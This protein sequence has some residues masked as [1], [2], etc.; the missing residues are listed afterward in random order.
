MSIGN[1]MNICRQQLHKTAFLNV[2]MRANVKKQNKEI[3]K[4]S[5]WN[6]YGQKCGQYVRNE[7]IQ[8]MKVIDMER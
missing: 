6:I 1:F 5:F 7:D 2:E 3:T 8:F 4:Q